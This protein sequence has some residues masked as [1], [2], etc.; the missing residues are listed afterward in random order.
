MA[1]RPCESMLCAPEVLLKYVSFAQ[2]N[3][4]VTRAASLAWRPAPRDVA[5]ARG[6]GLVASARGRGGLPEMRMHAAALPGKSRG[7]RHP[8]CPRTRTVPRRRL[9]PGRSQHVRVR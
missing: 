6:Y 7:P 4:L 1:S 8:L 3:D 9:G 5:P 2:A